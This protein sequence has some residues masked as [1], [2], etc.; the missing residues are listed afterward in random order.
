[1]ASIYINPADLTW[2]TWDRNKVGGENSVVD[3]PS[4]ASPKQIKEIIEIVKQECEQS[5]RLQSFYPYLFPSLTD[6][7]KA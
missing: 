3:L 4:N 2:W 5:L 1:M 6:S 7:D